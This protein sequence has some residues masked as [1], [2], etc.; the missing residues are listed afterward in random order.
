MFISTQNVFPQNIY[1]RFSAVACDSLIKANTNNPNFAILD[2]RTPGSWQSEHLEGSINRNYY[3]SDFDAQLNDLPKQK[4]FLIHCQSGGRSGGTFNKMKNL[5]FAEVYD[6]QG[7]MNAWKGAALPTSNK[8]APK[9]MLV[10]FQKI[11]KMIS[12]YDTI[13]VTIT[14]RANDTLRLQSIQIND[15][16][17]TTNFNVSTKLT[18]AQDYTFSIFAN[19]KF[20]ENQ[21]FGVTIGN[22]DKQLAFDINIK[23]GL[24]QNSI[25]LDISEIQVYPNPVKNRLY[26]SG[27]NQKPDEILLLDLSGKIVFRETKIQRGF[28]DL[29][30][31]KNG[32]YILKIKS[33]NSESTKKL[34]K[35]D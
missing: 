33:G 9:I 21:Q 3:D 10:G 22:N 31:I 4:T 14:N 20:D 12:A 28:I 25:P 8:M 18:G 5:N 15:P 30:N 32:M 23:N 7:G 16:Q 13:N 11:S 29:Q 27:S 2:V 35:I 6:M 34:I 1:K 24:I 26:I 19:P 17:L